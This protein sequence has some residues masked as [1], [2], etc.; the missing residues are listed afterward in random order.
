MQKRQISGVYD[1]GD[2][3]Y[4]DIGWGTN[5]GYQSASC[6]F[7]HVAGYDSRGST[8]N[9]P[10]D[11]PQQ[12]F[13]HITANR[14]LPEIVIDPLNIRKLVTPTA[15]WCMSAMGNAKERIRDMFD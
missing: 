10:I 12:I 14:S 15:F 8:I 13:S 3:G 2:T 4:M 5:K 9:R 7:P 1:V 11:F 6:G